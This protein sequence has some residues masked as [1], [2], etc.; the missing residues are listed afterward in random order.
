MPY[1]KLW[2]DF[3]KNAEQVYL[4]KPF[5]TRFSMKYCEKDQKVVL[6]VTD[7]V[8][9]R[10]SI[11]FQ[12]NALLLYCQRSNVKPKKHLLDFV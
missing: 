7:D 12:K 1:F 8:S 5:G 3:E 10:F 6:K 4:K 9:V 11:S 2:D